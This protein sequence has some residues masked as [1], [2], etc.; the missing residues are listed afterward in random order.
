MHAYY[1]PQPCIPL[2]REQ[3]LEVTRVV[4]DFL[5][6]ADLS[7]K[8]F[9]YIGILTFLFAFLSFTPNRRTEPAGM[10]GTARLFVSHYGFPLEWLEVYS[11]M[12]GDYTKYQTR[13]SGVSRMNIAW[14]AL[15]LDFIFCFLS[16]F[17]T[18]HGITK[19]THR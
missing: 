4:I 12:S 17:V 7:L 13:Y 15:I 3:Q 14:G 1:T 9:V 19:L 6:R 18:V 11:W 5:L 8:K 16:A 10:H 2:V